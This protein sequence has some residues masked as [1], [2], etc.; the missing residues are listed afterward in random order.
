M[1][2]KAEPYIKRLKA[3]YGDYI[4]YKIGDE[5]LEAMFDTSLLRK[6]V[7]LNDVYKAIDKIF[8]RESRGFKHQEEFLGKKGQLFAQ[9]Q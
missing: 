6:G 4:K 1:D 2:R 9:N 8:A 5:Q 3:K 7:T